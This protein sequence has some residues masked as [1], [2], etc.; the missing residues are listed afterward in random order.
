MSQKTYLPEKIMRKL[1]E[2][3]VLISQ[4]KTVAQ[5]TNSIGITE[6]TYYRWCKR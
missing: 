2:A 5:A 1:C 6:V 4:G 3:D